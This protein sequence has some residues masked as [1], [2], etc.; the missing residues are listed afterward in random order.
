MVVVVGSLA[1][2]MAVPPTI[3]AATSVRI[4]LIEELC[5]TDAGRGTARLA[6]GRRGSLAA[7]ASTLAGVAPRPIVIV[8]G[9]LVGAARHPTCET[10]G[11]IG[12]AQLAAALAELGS[13][14]AV[15]TDAPCA[16]AVRALLARLGSPAVVHV[17]AGPGGVGRPVAELVRGYRAA[18]VGAVVAVERVGPAADG[19]PRDMRGRSLSRHTAPLH[20]VLDAGPWCSI[21]IGDGGNELGMGLLAAE[22]VAASVAHGES[23]ACTVAC[24]HL[25]VA[26]TSNWGALGLVA[27]LALA[28]P[29]RHAALAA[30]LDLDRVRPAVEQACRAGDL[31]DGVTARPV[32][33]VDGLDW[34][35]YAAVAERV[36]ALADRPPVPSSPVL[37]AA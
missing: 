23:I 18:G 34:S 37:V 16:R 20:R 2:L 7:A 9:F 31:V 6:A 27:A 36:D 25:L 17:A 35:D 5:T 13:P 22:L 8:T 33:T 4:G 29:D 1:C 14:V 15:C 24:D 30:W 19:H 26:G 32:P 11:P 28:R 12:A 10:D 3:D 21:T